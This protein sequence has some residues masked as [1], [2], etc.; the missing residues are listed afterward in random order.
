MAAAHSI[1]TPLLFLTAFLLLLLV[2]LSVPIIKSIYLFQIG[3]NVKYGSGLFSVTAKAAVNFGVFGWCSTAVNVAVATFHE[4]D[5]AQCSPKKLGYSIG[6][7]VQKILSTLDASDIVD[8]IDKA[9]TFVLVLHPIACALAF[10]ALVFSLVTAL[11]PTSG[12][13]SSAIATG[14]GVLAAILATLVF[15]LD[16]VL[17][18]VAKSRLKKKTDGLG[19]VSFGNAEWITLGAALALWLASFGACWNIIRSRRQRKAE[20]RY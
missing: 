6:P 14:F 7:A 13:L 16:C 11:R 18:G 1:L 2:T 20:A 5:P 19:Y 17:T 8:V 3:T 4:N 12:R 10:V 9:L 15:I